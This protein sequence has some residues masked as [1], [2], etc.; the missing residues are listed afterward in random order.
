MHYELHH[1][2]RYYTPRLRA[3]KDLFWSQS[4]ATFGVAL[5]Q[6]LIPVYLLN[7]GY[8]VPEVLLF[9]AIMFA[10][11]VPSSVLST[12]AVSRFSANRV[13]AIGYFL[14]TL[15]FLALW[16][17]EDQLVPFWLPAVLKGIDRG[18]YWPPFHLTFSKSNSHKKSG[19]AKVGLLFALMSA[20]QGIAPAVGGLVATMSGIGWVYALAA[21]MLFVTSIIQ[22]RAP[23]IVKHRPMNWKLVNWRLLP[24]AISFF[25]FSSAYVIETV[26]WPLLVFLIIPSYAGIG[27][28]SSVVIISSAL[29]ALYVGRREGRKGERTY[30]QHGSTVQSISNFF[31]LLADSAGHVFGINLVGGIG[32]SLTATSMLS[33]YYRR[34]DTEPRLEYIAVMETSYNLG[35]FALTSVLLG[36]AILLPDRTALLSVIALAIPLT[37]GVRFIR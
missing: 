31:R 16:G 4:L 35:L 19:G 14:T 22:F 6:I 17:L 37:L 13:M 28:L 15:F 18:I 34:A 26:V 1:H 9:F 3:M 8:S 27:V 2:S 25:S 10:A 12:W 21:I 32:N 7:L 11:A 20:A 33:R 24:D 5:V 23:D 36:L 29:A 30:L